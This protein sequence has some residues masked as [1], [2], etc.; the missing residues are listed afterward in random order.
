MSK[1][2][3]GTRRRMCRAFSLIELLVVIAIIAL[4]IAILIPSLSGAREASRRVT[5]ASNLRQY[6]MGLTMYAADH[7]QRTPTQFPLPGYGSNMFA[8]NGAPLAGTPYENPTSILGPGWWD[9]REMLKNYFT[10]LGILNCPSL[11]TSPV[12][13]P[14]NTRAAC[15]YAFDYYGGRGQVLSGPAPFATIQDR[16]PDFGIRNGVPDNMD[17]LSVTP[18]LMPLTQDRLYYDANSS[19]DTANMFIYNHGRG[20]A[21]LNAGPGRPTATDFTNP[22]HAYRATTR[23]SDVGGSN[24]AFYD[25]HAAFYRLGDMDVVGGWHAQ[26]NGTNVMTISKLP[27]RTSSPVSIG[28]PMPP[29]VFNR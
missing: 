18:G 17:L 29:G 14:A 15:Y 25:G 26:P 9:L 10:S 27:T 1:D 12:T 21:F 19:G 16:W 20:T 8:C 7:K 23:S 11:K 24:I 22:S 4:L 28:W 13:D 3:V 5:C 2:I 6:A